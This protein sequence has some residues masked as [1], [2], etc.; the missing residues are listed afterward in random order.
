MAKNVRYCH[1]HNRSL[2]SGKRSAMKVTK[3]AMLTRNVS[4]YSMKVMLAL[5]LTA[6]LPNSSSLRP[7]P[8]L[9]SVTQ[10]M[11]WR[12]MADTTRMV[13]TTSHKLAP[14]VTWAT[15]AMTMSFRKG[16]NTYRGEVAGS[17]PPANAPS[18]ELESLWETWDTTLTP[19]LW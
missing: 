15:P 17:P 5:S 8:P 9:P 14:K 7:L 16:P 12:Y 1:S 13:N 19:V 10:R 2:R 6:Q 3:A 11:T 18:R 4:V